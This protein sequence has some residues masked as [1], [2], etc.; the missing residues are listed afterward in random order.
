MQILILGASSQVGLALT[1]AFASGNTLWLLGRDRVRLDEAVRV[2]LAAGAN[3]CTALVVDLMTFGNSDAGIAGEGPIDL[4]LD[5]A[6]A[7]SA[8]RDSEIPAATFFGLVLA[9]AVSRG[10]LMEALLSRQPKAPAIILIS[11]VLARLRSPDR[12]VYSALKQ[13]LESYY[14]RLRIERPE[15][16]L[17]VVTV[18]TVIDPKRPSEKPERLA[19]AVRQAYDEGRSSLF[20]G[21]IGKL[22]LCLFY[23]QPLV[24]FA[25]TR[26]QR[27]LRGASRK[28]NG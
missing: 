10:P 22:Y 17:L 12:L 19:A 8:F 5:A 21:G 2:G 27:I 4:I 26:L 16:R 3:R 28:A 9:D 20:F 11:T 14:R 24:F 13:L 18:G 6:S 15:L 23:L 25:V 1:R 7:S